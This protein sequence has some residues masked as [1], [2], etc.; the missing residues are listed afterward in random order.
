MVDEEEEEVPEEASALADGA[1]D[2]AVNGVV[3]G[4]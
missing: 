2:V 1:E 3:H 4:N